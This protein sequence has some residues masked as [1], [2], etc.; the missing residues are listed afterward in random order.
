MRG[1]VV[2]EAKEDFTADPVELFFDL[3]YVFAFAELVFEVADDPTPATVGRSL[4]LFALVWM[5]WTQFTWAANAVSGN[6]RAVRAWFRHSAVLD[7]VRAR[8]LRDDHHDDHRDADSQGV[9][10]P[11]QGL[12]LTGRPP[13]AD[14]GCRRHHDHGRRSC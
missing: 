10:R 3:S 2:P 8:A 5:T 1:V 12:S 9:P 7:R 11:P 14:E 13:A 4:V 6:Q